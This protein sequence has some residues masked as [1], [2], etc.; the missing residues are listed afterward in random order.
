MPVYGVP[1]VR[2]SFFLP[3]V[4]ERSHDFAK[5]GFQVQFLAG[6]PFFPRVVK[7]QSCGASNAV[8]RVEVLPRG[9]LRVAEKLRPPP[10]KRVNAGANPAAGTM[11]SN[12]AEV[13][14]PV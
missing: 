1:Q 10:S 13:R 7:L 5:V 2:G 6:G 12:S 11:E 4:K 9:P 8:L 3:V 14:T